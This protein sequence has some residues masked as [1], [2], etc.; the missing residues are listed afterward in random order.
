MK[1]VI[2]IIVILIVII[3]GYILFQGKESQPQP[4]SPSNLPAGISAPEEGTSPSSPKEAVSAPPSSG[5]QEISM[6][7]GNL[8]FSPGKL[9]LTKGQPVKITFQNSGL[10]T[11]TI[12]ELGVNV[13]LTGNSGVVEFVPTK[14]GVFEYYCAVPGHREGGMLGSLTVN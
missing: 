12:D 2:S 13:A 8:F 6:E 1:K 3:S 4:E 10:H 7:S 5:V 9:T 11:F 14:T